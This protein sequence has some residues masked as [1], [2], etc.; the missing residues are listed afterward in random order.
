MTASD[1]EWAWKDILDPAFP[2]V[3][4]HLLYP[5]KNAEAAKRGAVPLS[6]VGIE[7]VDEKTLVVTLDYP[8]PYFL[9]LISFCVFFPVKHTLDR[10]HPDWAYHAG[11]EFVSN[12][13]FVLK[14]W[15]H[16]NELVAVRN[17]LYWDRQT[18]RPEM[19]HFSMIANETTALQMFE[20]GELDLIGNLF[21]LSRSTL[22]P[23][24]KNRELF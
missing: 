9:D 13:P 24:S 19:I 5:I 8:T 16:N 20:N 6:E 1:F 21:L 14:E 2:S 4:A 22:L 23:L 11:S 12:G 3:N 18:V 10:E 7:A 15:K 17:P